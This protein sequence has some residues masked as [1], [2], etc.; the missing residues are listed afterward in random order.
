[1]G[2][3]LLGKPWGHHLFLQMEKSVA[4]TATGRWPRNI[5][6]IHP[7][8]RYTVCIAVWEQPEPWTMLVESTVK[9][10]PPL[11]VRSWATMYFLTVKANLI[12]T[13]CYL[14]IKIS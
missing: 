9:P 10:S 6:E 11:N 5:S 14:K 12:K 13:F 2:W 7:G 3:G 1:M 8:I 4:L